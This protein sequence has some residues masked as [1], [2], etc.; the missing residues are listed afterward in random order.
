[1]NVIICTKKKAPCLR[2]QRGIADAPATPMRPLLQ[3]I[4]KKRLYRAKRQ[5]GDELY[6]TNGMG[7]QRVCKR[8]YEEM[9]FG[10]N[11]ADQAN[12]DG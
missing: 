11:N 7:T 12:D 9:I 2:V 3:G 6:D 1:M 5:E 4:V 10:E 8:R